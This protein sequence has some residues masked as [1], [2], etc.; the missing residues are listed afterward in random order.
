M[1]YPDHSANHQLPISNGFGGYDTEFSVVCGRCRNQAFRADKDW[2]LRYLGAKA[3]R[4][5]NQMRDR[6]PYR[7]TEE[8]ATQVLAEYIARFRHAGLVVD[9]DLEMLGVGVS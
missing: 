2:A 6:P 1:S 4:L 9:G 8:E 5:A 3:R 7:L